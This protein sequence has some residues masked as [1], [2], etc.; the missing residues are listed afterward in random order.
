MSKEIGLE[1]EWVNWIEEA[2]TKNYFKH[3][4]YKH[5]SNIQEIGSGIFGKVY[6][7]N[8]KNSHRH[9][10]L[11]SFFNF[12]NATVKEIVNEF[13]LQRKVDFYD[14]IIRFC[15]VTR[16]DDS[17]KYLLVME[18]ADGGTLHDY[19]KNRF[20]NL[21]WN[22]KFNLAFQL[23]HAVSYLHDEEIEH[24]DLHS[25]NIL[26][27]QNTIKLA[28]FGLSKRIAETSNLQSKLFGL[29]PYIDPKS[30]S[31]QDYKLNEKS[32]IYSV[33]ILLWEISSG[34]P[35]FDNKSYDIYLAINISQGL[36]E[37]PIPNT[38]EDYVKIYTDCWNNEPDSRPTINQ[39]ITKL[40]DFQN[41]NDT[42]K[43]KD[44]L[45]DDDRGVTVQLVDDILRLQ[46][47]LE[48]YVT[49]LRPKIEVNLKNVN[50]LLSKY[51]SKTRWSS[52]SSDLP[53]VKAVLQRHVLERIFDY[54][55]EYSRQNSGDSH[56]LEALIANKT[57]ELILLIE[58]FRKTREGNDKITPSVPVKI[59]QQIYLSL[60]SRGFS[61]ITNGQE[62][63][64]HTFIDKFKTKLNEEMEQYRKILDPTKK[65]EIEEKAANII[66]DVARIFFFRIQTQEPIGQIHWFQYNDKIDPGLMVGIWDDDD[67]LDD[68]VVDICKFPLIGIELN[69][70]LKR[71]V[72]TRA[73][74]HP[75]R[76]HSQVNSDNK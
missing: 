20:G 15:G 45:S 24:R 26:I 4:D 48:I 51:K 49:N 22:D 59:R 63:C 12:N 6:R 31:I 62:T 50:C 64:E 17:K 5:F 13:K 42:D 76:V 7:T 19:L 28:D 16:D 73:I 58:R 8:W 57:E 47:A 14:N 61:N 2:I 41:N 11:K 68:L 67:E 66:L 21:T 39:V 72:Y 30:F 44:Q 46:D 34:K 56:S 32:D 33:G 35:P 40:K 25:K 52:K 55:S 60:G 70:V 65:R 1:N 36:R 71:R 37:T 74:I 69:D 27:H 43:Q 18:Y 53:L 3:Y 38:P 23:V 10:A 9:L 29:I 54:V 75:Q